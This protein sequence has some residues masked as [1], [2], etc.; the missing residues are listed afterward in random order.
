MKTTAL[1]IS[2][3]ALVTLFFVSYHSLAND[4]TY[5]VI[6]KNGNIKFISEDDKQKEL[7]PGNN[8]SL[9]D[10]L[11]I[12][13]ESYLCF[14]NSKG[15]IIECSKEG[16]FTVGD[17][18]VK[19]KSTKNNLISKYAQYLFEAIKEGTSDKDKFKLGLEREIFNI[20]KVCPFLPRNCKISNGDIKFIWFSKPGAKEYIFKLKNNFS[21]VL[22]TITT[23]D[24]S[25]ILTA[26]ELEL[27]PSECYHWT[28]MVS[29]QDLTLSDE[30]YFCL[31]SEI[32]NDEVMLQVNE[33]KSTMESENS[34]LEDMLLAKFYES[35]K[36]FLDAY[37][38]YLRLIRTN[39]E[40]QE[41]NNLYKDFLIN[42]KS[43]E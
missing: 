12:Q 37:D 8:L 20:D 42:V 24:T 21:E 29:G 15:N 9:N 14:A 40:N 6:I 19:N 35:K 32:E 43:A 13:K 31:L 16:K 2:F 38:C 27:N 26:K 10:T 28:I 25:L 22:K 36:M 5:K 34:T 23:A 30:S 1:K 11:I 7:F 41:I 4:D 17:L 3:V 39:S 33:I 18:V